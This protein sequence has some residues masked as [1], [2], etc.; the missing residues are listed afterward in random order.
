MPV[1]EITQ[2]Q[3]ALGG[4]VTLSVVTESSDK[5]TNKLFD[6]LWRQVYIF[7]KRFSRFLP[8]SE[9]SIFNRS[10]GIKSF[11][12]PE[13]RDLLIAAKKLGE[14]TD[15]LYNPFILPALQR[16]GYRKSALIG[17][18]NDVQED[19]SRRQ[20]A[21]V[22]SLNIGDNWACIPYGTALDLGG[23]GKGYLADQLSKTINIAKVRGYWLS[24]S[25]DIATFGLDESDNKITLNVQNAGDPNMVSDWIIHSPESYFAVATSGTFKRRGQDDTNNWHHII[26]PRSLQPA[27]TDILLAT[28]CA[29]TV[30]EADVL[31]S[32]AL[33]IGSKL[34]L[35]FLRRHGA[36]DA[37]LQ[38]VDKDGNRFEK[39][40]GHH[41]LKNQPLSIGQVAQNA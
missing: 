25:G 20:V 24:I 23:C 8:M 31:A 41:I 14:Q 2:T 30:L 27:N 22:K 37:L 18:E 38:C 6:N 33:I 11:I 28:V 39:R 21:P 9:L 3:Q 12:S 17:Y 26:D 10:A 15:N 16:A 1:N 35:P 7:E 34:A 5:D 29:K 40:F 19:Y 36:T 4:D 32:S 13:F